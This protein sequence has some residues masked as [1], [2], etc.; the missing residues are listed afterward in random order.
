MIQA[1]SRSRFFITL[2]LC[3]SFVLSLVAQKDYSELKA[4]YREQIQKIMKKRS[5]PGASILLVE[6]DQVIWEEYF[7]YADPEA[8]KIVDEKTL[9]KIGSVSK[10]FTATA[11]MQQV[12]KGNLDLDEPM[13]KYLPNFKIKQRFTDAPPI[14]T[15]MVMTHHAGLPCDLLRGF[16]S[17]EVEPYT[18]ELDLLNE[19]YTIFPP[20]L[21]HAYSNPGYNLLGIL[22]G[23]LNNTNYMDNVKQD[24]FQVLG[25]N[26]S[27]FLGH[28]KTEPY[29]SNGYDRK[30]KFAYEGDLRQIPAGGILSTVQD[31]SKFVI[32]WLPQNKQEKILEKKY[33]EEMWRTQNESVELDMDQDYGLAWIKRPKPGIG[34]VYFHTGA[35]L[36]QNALLAIAPEVNLGI[37]LLTNSEN[38]SRLGG[39]CYKILQEAAKINAS[40]EEDKKAEQL[41]DSP[42]ER[43]ELSDEQLNAYAGFYGY[44]QGLVTV[45]KKKKNLRMKIEGQK[46]KL[47]PVGDNSFMVKVKLFGLIGIKIKEIRARFEEVG[48]QEVLVQEEVATGSK[49]VIANRIEPK[50]I[51]NAWR[52]RIGTYEIINYK[53]GDMAILESFEVLEK[54][55][56]LQMIANY[57]IGG[58]DKSS[59]ALVLE[60]DD[61]AYVAGLGRQG[62]YSVQVRKNDQGEDCLYFLGFLLKKVK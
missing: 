49:D 47:I 12:Q 39:T 4:T 6:G 7:G 17:D 30:G 37:I 25:M 33:K 59:S 1:N 45:E 16:I 10:L 15:R 34:E 62:G 44:P 51:S 53:T 61:L 56:F 48:G 58:G 20:N 21:I 55:G 29:L 14:T 2:L 52:E 38:G 19:E 31:L 54:D 3:L 57:N 13:K 42:S 43:V 11:L 32:E 36:Y 9:F 8:G 60:S 18:A 35:T 41:V 50:P 24:I 46:V 23:E 40:K 26:H 5:I 22:A 28:D 27:I